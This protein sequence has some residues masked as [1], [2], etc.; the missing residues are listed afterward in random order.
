MKISLSNLQEA[1]NNPR[2]FIRAQKKPR[3]GF[4]YSRYL[5]LRGVALGYHAQ[6]DLGMSEAL[7]EARLTQKFKGTKG[8]VECL[9][10]FRDYV[11]KY[12][13]LGTTVAKVRDR[14]RVV[15]PDEYADYAIT[16]EIARLDLYPAGG[17]RAWS[18]AN[19]T[20][21]WRDEIR[22]PLLQGACAAQL[23]V[24]VDEVVPGVYD[25]SRSSYTELRYS[26]NDIQSVEE[27][28]RNS[29]ESS[30]SLVIHFTTPFSV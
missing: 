18:L 17:Y 26:K 15:L 11:A 3:T 12:T 27:N 24:D 29:V 28:A 7:L 13:A 19:R 14:V 22:F 6:N 20:E 21:D 4:R 25:F 30:G 16:G 8:N 9:E 1:I 10:Q 5:M 2:A 23:N